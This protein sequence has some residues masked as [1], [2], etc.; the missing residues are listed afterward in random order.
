[1]NTR[2]KLGGFIII[3]LI[4][5]AISFIL[6]TEGQ[7]GWGLLGMTISFIILLPLAFILADKHNKNKGKYE[8]IDVN[9]IKTKD[10]NNQ[11]EFQNALDYINS[12]T[13]KE[14]L[15]YLIKMEP[16][17]VEV[18]V[19]AT[20][21]NSISSSIIQ[22]RYSIGYNRAARIID[23]LISAGIL[24]RQNLILSSKVSLNELPSVFNSLFSSKW[25]LPIETNRAMANQSNYNS[26]AKQTLFR[27]EL[28]NRQ[29]IFAD[30]NKIV[31]TTNNFETFERRM[32]DL[33]DHIEWSYRMQR[34]GMPVNVNMTYEQAI[35]DWGVCYND[36]AVRIAK[37]ISASADTAQKAKNRIPKIE[38]IRISLKDSPNKRGSGFAIDNLIS[39]LKSKINQP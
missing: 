20:I 1:M 26:I 19:I 9:A 18:S 16:L 23:M 34:E 14:V 22:R 33:L 37:H 25:N 24:E 10:E 39:K 32:A 3:P 38:Q 27:V 6:L 15:D 8:A 29:R 30:S 17:F 4:G 7:I 35:A 21:S 28:E 2:I 12:N 11:I 5:V 13:D 31:Q 36:N